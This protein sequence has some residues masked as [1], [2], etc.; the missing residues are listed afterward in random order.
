[1]CLGV[2]GQILS[3]Q[4]DDPLKRTARVSFGGI[5]KEVNLA[6]APEARLGDYV[7]VHVG[8]AI[9]RVDEE[10]ATKIF[11]YLKEMD[12]LRDLNG[13]AEKRSLS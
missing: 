6:Y 10:E 9:S 4:G 12:E 1:M 3:I 13:T 7:I 5:I 8:F 11:A 2:P